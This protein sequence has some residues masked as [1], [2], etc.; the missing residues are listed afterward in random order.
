MLAPSERIGLIAGSGSLPLIF[1]RELRSRGLQPLVAV[2]H[3]G[4]T[5]PALAGLVDELLW[6]HLGQF[7][8]IISFLTSRRATQV[9][10]LGGITK[11]KIWRIRPDAL[12]L[13]LVARLPHL[14]D[15]LLLRA[16]AQELEQHQ[17]RV[18]G[19]GEL[20]P[21]ML[22]Q[23]GLLTGVPPT[24]VQWADLRI[25]WRAAKALGALDIGQ[26]V[27]VRERVVVAVEAIEGTDA[28]M[29]RAGRLTHGK[30]VL[31]KVAKPLQDDRLDLPTVG[32]RTI[33]VA[34]QA[35][36]TAIALEAGRTLMLDPGATVREAERH[37]MVLLGCTG[38]EWGEEGEG[39][40]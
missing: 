7:K 39:M 30:G 40:Q 12:A 22:V 21:E 32:P 27:V 8:R 9:V 19:V 20:L 5:D 3:Q 33:E 25:G 6:V 34:A 14:Q 10:L 26:G 31:V 37:R 36:I 23:S 11:A 17:L 15:D 35:G 13:R 28:M 29:E 18:R 4:E 24:P 2:A 1:A 38:Q 16:I